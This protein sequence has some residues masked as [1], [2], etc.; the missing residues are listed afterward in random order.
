[1]FY[2]Y[3][4]ADHEEQ[5]TALLAELGKCV[6]SFERVCAA[7]RNCIYCAFR[8]EGLNQDQCH[9]MMHKKSVRP[10]REML[11]DKF[12]KLADQD[13][14]DRTCV[15]TLLS[16]IDKLAEQRN[17][18]VHSEWHLNFD[19]ENA[20]EDFHALALKDLLPISINNET[21]CNHV[22]EAT[23]I[24]VLLNRLAICLNQ[25]GF[26]VSEMFVKSLSCA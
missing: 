1:M 4:S 10:L 16:R 5:A 14:D 15:T 21:L 26:K 13:D 9:K 11:G 12:E 3:D 17:C 25:K 7:L 8:K 24:Q 18:F 2:E 22:H 6:V 20:D 23:E 19:Y